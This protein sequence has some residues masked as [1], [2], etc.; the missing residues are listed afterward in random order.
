MKL[1]FEHGKLFVDNVKFC[2]YEA[3][4]GSKDLQPGQYIVEARYSHSFGKLLPH[5]DG[6]G[7][8]G[9]DAG[10]QVVLGRVMSQR[11]LIPDG[12]VVR[13]LTTGI[14]AAHETD[15]QVLAE[16]V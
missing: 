9:N 11:G 7:W 13:V 2:R 6:I 1:S 5:V 4:D 12:H 15:I 16:V 10:C 3:Q 14:E 8:L